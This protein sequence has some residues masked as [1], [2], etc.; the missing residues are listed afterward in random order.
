VVYVGG[1]FTSIGG[2]TRHYIAA[3]DAAFGGAT[4]WNPDAD[5]YVFALAMSGGTLFAGG[6]FTDIGLQSRN[7]IAALD[8]ASGATTSWNPNASGFV[9]S[10][11]A[12]GS[13][14][15]AGGSFSS[16]GCQPRSYIAALDAAT[17][18][19]TSWHPNASNHVHALAVSGGTVY[20]GG[21]FTTIGG[22]PRSR[23]AALDATS[24][25][26]TAWNPNAN[27]FV[28]A[29]AVSGG[30]VYA[31]GQF[32]SVSGQP[33]NCIAA[34]DA[35]SGVV[36]SWNPNASGT[37]SAI[38]A[39]S[40]DGSTVY[41]GGNFTEIGGQLRNH[42]AALDAVTAEATPWDPN[43]IGS[44]PYGPTIY[45]LTVSGGTVYVGG[46]FNSIGGQPRSN[47]AAIDTETGAATAWNPNV[48]GSDQLDGPVVYALA[49]NGGIVYLGGKFLSLSGIPRRHIAAV[50]A[51][52]G[53]VTT[54]T[55]NAAGDTNATYVRSLA[56]SSG[57]TV[58]C[59]GQFTHIGGVAR[60]FLAGLAPSS[61]PLATSL[62]TPTQSDLHLSPNP[63][64][65]GTQVRY[66]VARAGR[67]RLEVLDVS[68]RVE[69]TLADRIHTPGRYVVSWD[70]V[71]G[72]GRLAPGLHFVRLIA[73]DRVT[74]GKLAII[75]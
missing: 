20:A 1:Q 52:T 49:V 27:G 67:V 11:A 5:G 25:D 31:G 33:R 17:G 24:G 57:G 3:L 43:A 62:A 14:V 34:I 41:A 50:D 8:A 28:A 54:W 19:P 55:A 40:V 60:P 71:V 35:T 59:G 13:T 72:R 70:G 23:I 4:A 2:K 15:Y 30:I 51:T 12:S 74:V 66:S 29:L 65:R 58:Y 32:T 68:G 53:S 21:T 39:L 46:Q 37:P 69:E 7:Y 45:A 56:V 10:L 61:V 36:T 73:P 22:Q 63:T 18:A 26:A 42:I 48:F 38:Y 47:V 75:R 16:I 9:F 64:T 6:Q 44:P